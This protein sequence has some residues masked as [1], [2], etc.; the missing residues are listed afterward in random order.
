MQ[1]SLKRFIKKN[2]GI[3]LPSIINVQN[4]EGYLDA[5]LFLKQKWLGVN[6]SLENKIGR[7][8]SALARSLLSAFRNLPEPLSSISDTING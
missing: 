3:G 7:T 6:A 4:N 2:K 1:M 5:V 8:P